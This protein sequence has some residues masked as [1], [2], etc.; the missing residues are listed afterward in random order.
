M[1]VSDYVE[2]EGFDEVKQLEQDERDIFGEIVF[3]FCFGSIYHLQ[4]FN[5]D[6]TPAT[7]SSWTT[8]GS[9]FSTS[10]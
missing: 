10:A 5:A 3:R 8:G 9:R 6:T 1:L 7:T 4:H 2:G